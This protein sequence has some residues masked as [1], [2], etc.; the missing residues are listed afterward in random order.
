MLSN[1]PIRTLLL[2]SLLCISCSLFANNIAVSNIS[3][4]GR[5][6]GAQ[7][8]LVQFNLNWQNSWKTS[9]APFN[10]DAAWVF[11]KYK[12]GNGDWKHAT[13]SSTG[14]TIPSGANSTQNDGTGMFIYR[15][16]DGTGT[17]SLSGIQLLWNYGSDGVANESKIT[18]RVYAV[19]MVYNQVGGFQAGSGGQNTG[20][21]RT[22]TDVSATGT[23]ATFTV[24]GTSP[25][26]QGNSSS[27]SPTN[28]A[29]RSNASS[30]LTGTNTASLASGYPTGFNAFYAMKYEISQQQYV[31]F[32]NTLTYTQQAARTIVAPNSA[33]G[34]PA[35]V[36]SNANR[37]GIDIQTPGTSSTV[38]AVYACNL[39]GNSTYNESDDGQSIACNYLSW[40]DLI[41]YLDWAALRPMTELEY[42]KSCRGSQNPAS[43][44]FAWGNTSATA[45]SGLSNA[46]TMSETA[47]NT[48]FNIAYNNAYTS[49]PVRTGI[50]ATSSTA[51]LTSG[52]GYYGNMELSGN[53]WERVVTV[54][55]AT[56]RAFSGANGNGTLTSVGAADVSGWPAAAGAGWKGGSWLNTTTNSATTSDRAQAA[57]ADNSRSADAGGRGVRTISSGIVANGLVLWLDAG[58]SPSYSG[59]GTT[60]TDLSGNNNN[61]TL[62]NGPTYSSTNGGIINFDGSNYVSVSINLSTSNHTIVAIARYSGSISKRVISSNSGNWLLGWHFGNANMYYAEGWVSH[63]GVTAGTAWIC[64]A[65]T[66]NYTSDSW[67]LYR[68]GVS[69]AG[70][71][72]LGNQ[73]P[74]GIRL[75]G[76][77]LADE[78]STCQV[79][80]VLAYNRVLSAAEVLQNFNALKSRFGL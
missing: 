17:F 14:H 16:V 23:A 63:P 15:S 8:L 19:E 34:T 30:D 42:E 67:E 80:V 22:A 52:A 72:N 43:N 70:P 25:T 38:P 59:S 39:N 26:V 78:S 62:V 45:L 71:N 6:I 18:V 60:W 24:T 41:A 5:N 44:E 10:W 37:N 54:G 1:T 20:E 28:I 48:S 56:G 61:G 55:N 79:G 65:G 66:G 31:E 57:N 73:G 7:T 47:S 9:A 40:D 27:A 76:T 53:L 75:G 13:L 77:G 58:I 51:R 49:G 46:S 3:L 32:L 21:L 64:Y 69:I 68:N 11:V 35:L 50:F 4:T 29:A 2:S 36:A 33:A 74:N 12:V